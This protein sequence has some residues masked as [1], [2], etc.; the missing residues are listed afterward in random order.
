LEQLISGTVQSRPEGT[1][2]EQEEQEETEQTRRSRRRAR[3]EQSRP[4]RKEV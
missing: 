2:V 1:S 3:V 4:E